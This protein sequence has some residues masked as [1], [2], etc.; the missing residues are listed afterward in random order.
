MVDNYFY[1]Y[2]AHFSGR[3]NVKITTNR[4]KMLVDIMIIVSYNSKYKVKTKKNI[5]IQNCVKVIFLSDLHNCV[6]GNKNDKLYKAIQAEMP[7][8][9]LIG[10]DMLVAKEGS[11]V[12][13][14]LEFVKKLPHICQVYYTNGNHEQRMKENTDIYG[15]TYERYKAK[16]ENCGVCFLENKAENIEK[17]GMKFSIY[18]LELDS[19][20]NRK[21]KK[22]DV[23]EKT[24]EEKI[25]K[26]GKD[27]S[28][29]MAHNPAYMDAYKKWGADLI[30]S[31]HLHGGLVRCP[32]IGAVVTPQGFLFPKY[33][34]EMRR[35]GEQT[36]VVSR[37]LGSHTINI[38]LFNMPEVIAIEV[39]VR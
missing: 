35:E 37:G 39:C 16:L 20:V 36:I 33:S 21:F 29:L 23:T 17:N 13:E 14:A 28:I 11:S 24:V 18:G 38:R 27:Y 3:G 6:Y 5:G 10:G 31:G 9:I 7:D 30:L 26:K 1:P 2:F 34:G 4:V 15:D 22:A 25:G 8:M 19:S 12:Q 32:G